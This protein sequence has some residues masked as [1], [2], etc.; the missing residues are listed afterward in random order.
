MFYLDHD[1]CAE[2][3][4]GEENPEDVIDKKSREQESG[5]LETR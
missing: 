5:D 1:I 4:R 3:I 2:Y